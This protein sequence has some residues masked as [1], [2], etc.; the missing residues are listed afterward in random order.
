MIDLDECGLFVETANRKHGK[1]YV[2]LRVREPGPYS[3]SE[4]WNLLMAICGEDGVQGSP[5]RRWTKLWLEGGTTVDRMMEF[6]LE[7]LEDLGPATAD[8]WY[9]FT[10]DNLNSH[11]N[12]GLIA[13]IHAYGH[14]VAFRAPYYAVDGAIEFVFNNLQTLIRSRLYEVK[15][16]NTLI[17]VINQSIQSMENFAPYFE[18]VG[19]ILP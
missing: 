13:L 10:M 2:G 15:D 1:S 17:A 3:K 16:G 4:K 14:G 6:V 12:V 7:I 9:C 8:N 5:S 18:N 11:R 19:F